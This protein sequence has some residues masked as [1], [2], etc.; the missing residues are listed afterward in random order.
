MLHDNDSKDRA[1]PRPDWPLRLRK[2]LPARSTEPIR[3]MALLLDVPEGFR[4]VRTVKLKS[5]SVLVYEKGQATLPERASKKFL[6]TETKQVL[7]TIRFP[8]SQLFH[9]QGL[10]TSQNHIA[11]T[12]NTIRCKCARILGGSR[13]EFLPE[14]PPDIQFSLLAQG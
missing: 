13:R 4:G 5:G 6:V 1:K 14:I 3:Y 10:T 7:D 2:W 11:C 12:S 8:S 9:K